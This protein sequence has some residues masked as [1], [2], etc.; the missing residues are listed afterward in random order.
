MSTR[1]SEHAMV[2]ERIQRRDDRDQHRERAETMR[3]KRR[4]E[5]RESAEEIR[6]AMREMMSGEVSA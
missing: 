5:R 2:E 3:R 4:C 1:G 6:A